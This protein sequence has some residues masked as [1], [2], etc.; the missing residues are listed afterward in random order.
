MEK[1]P[2]AK[3]EEAPFRPQTRMAG[4]AEF[5]ATSEKGAFRRG[6]D[7]DRFVGKAGRRDRRFSARE[8]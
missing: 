2:F 4:G 6:D 8:E 5:F 1:A 7:L 3:M